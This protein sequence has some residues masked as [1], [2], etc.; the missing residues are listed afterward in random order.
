MCSTWLLVSPLWMTLEKWTW[1][2]HTQITCN[3]PNPGSAFDSLRQISLMVRRVRSTCQIWVVIYHQYGIS[4]ALSSDVISLEIP[5]TSDGIAK[6]SL[7]PQAQAQAFF[8]WQDVMVPQIYDLVNTYRPEYIWSDGEWE[9]P[10][11]YWKSK[12]FLAWLYNDRY[13]VCTVPLIFLW[14]TTH[15]LG[16]TFLPFTLPS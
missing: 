16:N 6:C 9:A 7:F 11:T 5:E 13:G 3:S 8:F 12:E 2:F 15:G 4:F 10:D 1:L 14:I